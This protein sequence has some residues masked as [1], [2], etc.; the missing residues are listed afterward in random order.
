MSR[1]TTNQFLGGFQTGLT[2]T[3][4]YSHRTRLEDGNFGFTKMM[5]CNISAAKRRVLISCVVT[6]Q[7]ICS[8]VFAWAKI[9]FSHEVAG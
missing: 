5:N 1:N 8:F 7:L 9:Q 2:Q 6:V 4:L 3:F